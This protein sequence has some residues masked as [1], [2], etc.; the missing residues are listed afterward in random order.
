MSSK[1]GWGAFRIVAA[2]AT[3]SAGLTAAGVAWADDWAAV[4][5]AAKQEKTIVLYSPASDLSDAIIAGYTKAYPWAE[6]KTVVASPG[7]LTSRAVTEAKANAPTAD[8]IMV[9]RGNQKALVGGDVVVVSQ[10][11]NDAGMT[12]SNVDSSYRSHPVYINPIVFLYNTTAVQPADLPKDVYGMTDPKWKNKI[13]FDRPSNAATGADFLASPRTAWGDDKWM[14]W[15][16]GLQANNIFITPDGT[17]AYQAALRGD[18]S[19]AVQSANQLSGID[20]NTPMKAFAY[21]NVVN[22]VQSIWLTKNAA[23]PNAAKFFINWLISA[24]GQKVIADSGR[25]PALDSVPS[26]LAP[27][28]PPPSEVKYAPG[29]S[30]DDFYADPD[31]YLAVYNQFWPN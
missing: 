3:V 18:A 25:A 22:F 2:V 21:D 23:H 17:S 7:V 5:A 19:F 11:P 14:A 10:V 26:P 24:D 8:V 29:N 16:K 28:M 13:A 9:P 4:E 1:Y 20:P 6:I 12:P 30:L 27:V 15:L 31:K